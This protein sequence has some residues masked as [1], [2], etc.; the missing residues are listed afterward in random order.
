MFK[1]LLMG[2][3][4]VERG[5]GS[6]WEVQISKYAVGVMDCSYHNSVVSF[7]CCG[8]LKN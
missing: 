6:S 5:K 2:I 8:Q 4:W 3:D 1:I 7:T